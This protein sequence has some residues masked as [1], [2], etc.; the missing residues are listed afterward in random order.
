M[1]VRIILYLRFHDDNASVTMPIRTVPGRRTMNQLAVFNGCLFSVF[2]FSRAA[3]VLL[4]RISHNV[5]I[6]IIVI[7]ITIIILL[8]ESPRGRTRDNVTPYNMV[9]QTWRSRIPQVR[10]VRTPRPQSAF[11]GFPYLFFAAVINLHAFYCF[12]LF[13]AIAVKYYPPTC[14]YANDIGTFD[15]HVRHD[16]AM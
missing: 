13:A 2:F 4:A 9:A 1:C 7:I 3:V 12:A 5:I 14:P 15:V 11:I 10:V 16:N 8:S 6:I